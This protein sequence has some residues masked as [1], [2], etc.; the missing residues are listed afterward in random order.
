MFQKYK[1]YETERIDGFTGIWPNQGE[2]DVVV[3]FLFVVV[4]VVVVGSD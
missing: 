4:V 3:S 2:V 1:K